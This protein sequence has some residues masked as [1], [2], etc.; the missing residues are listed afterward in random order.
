MTVT[1]GA[2]QAVAS[3]AT[4]ALSP[5]DD[6]RSQLREATTIL[7]Y[8]DGVYT[9]LATPRREVTVGIPLRRDNGEIELLIGHR[10]Q[11]NVSRGP[12]KGGLRYSPDVTL[13]EVRALAMWM[14]WKCAL[15]DVPY[16]GAKG[17]VRIDPRQ[18]S[19]AELERVTR[20]Y[21][22]EISP[23]IGPAHD[24][25]APD[26]GTDENTM[27]WLM[28]TY[29]VQ[30]GHTVLGVTTGKPVSLGGSLGRATATSRGVVHVALAALR[31][32]GIT[33]DGSTAA[34]QGFG[35]V[36]SH[37][38][39]FLFDNGVRVVAVSDQ[40]GA[41]ANA[42]GLDVPALEEHV[43]A[44]GSV[45]GFAGG[46]EIS[47]A[48]LLESDVDL[49]VPAAIE[50]VIHEG[51]AHRIRARV[52][53]EGANGPTTPEA[54]LVLNDAGRLVV[55]DILANAGGVIVSYF[56]W[57]QANQAYWWRADEVESRLAERMLTAWDEVSAHAAKLNLPLRT[58]ATCL[59]V[60]RVAQ[61]A[62]L[63]G[64]YP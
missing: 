52:I 9:V 2:P 61:A 19:A 22:S 17:G 47:G 36:G 60:E 50:G 42:A 7:G 30:K 51:N 34:V 18:Y 43:A 54:D 33:V 46:V 10:V 53:V 14:T 29:S 64:L 12:A 62:Q 4:V 35:K 27:A 56:E 20:R 11:H 3:E 24:I 16:G 15:L 26:V 21:T 39:R 32:R 57:V 38:A 45:V 6:A 8:D 44:T 59:A 49:L 28:D 55:P 37:A 63:R 58:A 5:L 1:T 40:Y 25:P 41:V 48:D 31:S 13:D 23:I